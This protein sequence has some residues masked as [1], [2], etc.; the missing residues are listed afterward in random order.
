[1]QVPG[2][3]LLS[4]VSE[5]IV[6]QL[7][8]AHSGEVPVPADQRLPPNQEEVAELARIALEGDLHS[9]LRFVVSMADQGVSVASILLL[10]VAP[11]AR[12]VRER[13]LSEQST[14]TEVTAALGVIQGVI[15][16]LRACAAPASSD[17]DERE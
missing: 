9:A 5:E 7:V 13:W 2:P 1:M 17:P 8:L 12:C 4:T 11:A 3:D 10:L 6:P 15:E 14:F 16:E